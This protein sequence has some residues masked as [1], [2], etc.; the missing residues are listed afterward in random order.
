[1]Q[2]TLY[3]N[4]PLSNEIGWSGTAHTPTISH[5][6]R[7]HVQGIVP[8]TCQNLTINKEEE[9]EEDGDGEEEEVEEEEEEEEEEKE[10]KEEE[11]QEEEEEWKKEEWPKERS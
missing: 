2:K 8:P 4:K 7:Q 10:E 5:C 1:M 6:S 9:E 11:E 3:F